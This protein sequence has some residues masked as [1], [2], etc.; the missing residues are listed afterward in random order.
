MSMS[1]HSAGSSVDCLQYLLNLH[2]LTL[3][4]LFMLLVTFSTTKFPN[5]IEL[6][7]FK[8]EGIFVQKPTWIQQKNTVIDTTQQRS[9]KNPVTLAEFFWLQSVCQSHDVVCSNSASLISFCLLA[10]PSP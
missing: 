4:G 10:A 9:D 8:K 2:T 1:F 5:F 3:V 6:F 7:L